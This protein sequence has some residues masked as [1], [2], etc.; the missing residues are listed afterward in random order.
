MHGRRGGTAL[1]FG[2]AEEARLDLTKL[3]TTG[4]GIAGFPAPGPTVYW[5]SC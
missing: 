2:A 1:L 4:L 5:A 3:A